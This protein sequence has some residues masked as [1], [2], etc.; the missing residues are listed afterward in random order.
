MS[1]SKT[2]TKKQHNCLLKPHDIYSNVSA[3]EKRSL[4]PFCVFISS[5]KI[6]WSSSQNLNESNRYSSLVQLTDSICCYR[7]ISEDLYES[8]L[9]DLY[10]GFFFCCCHFGAWSQYSLTFITLKKVDRIKKKSPF[11]FHRR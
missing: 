7:M 10:D 9:W 4:L 3:W 11:V 8:L 2:T 1:K 6:S 5:Q